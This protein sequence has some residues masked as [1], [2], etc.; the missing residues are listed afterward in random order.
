MTG[1]RVLNDLLIIIIGKWFHKLRIRM[2]EYFLFQNA[3]LCIILGMGLLSGGIFSAIR[4]SQNGGLHD[5]K[6]PDL[7]S[8]VSRP[9]YCSKLDKVHNYQTFVAVS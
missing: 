8:D 7:T 4:S 5:R 6:C 1:G 3:L 9:K 2:H